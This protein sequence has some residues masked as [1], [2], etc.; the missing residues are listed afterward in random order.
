MFYLLL[1]SNTLEH[2]VLS[3]TIGRVWMIEGHRHLKEHEALL[4]YSKSFLKE[5]HKSLHIVQLS[6]LLS[7]LNA[8]LKAARLVHRDRHNCGTIKNGLEIDLSIF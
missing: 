8:Q 5:T 4:L 1:Q 7:P 2:R 3:K 6:V